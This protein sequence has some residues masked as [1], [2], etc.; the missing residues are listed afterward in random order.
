MPRGDRRQPWNAGNLSD[1]TTWDWPHNLNLNPFSWFNSDEPEIEDNFLDQPLN[2]PEI[3]EDGNIKPGWKLQ[4]QKNP[5]TGEYETW[6]ENI[7]L[8]ANRGG[9]MSLV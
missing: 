4:Q 1:P 9:L 6:W 7:S 3:D 2:S 5:E 8:R